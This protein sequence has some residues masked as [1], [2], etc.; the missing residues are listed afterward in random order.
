[1]EKGKFIVF[2]GVDG[3][4]TTTQLDL[5][6]NSLMQSGVPNITTQEPTGRKIGKL[7]RDFL[8]VE[9]ENLPNTGMA[10][11]FMADRADH[12]HN[13]IIP[14]LE[15]GNH[16]LC[17][18]YLLSTLAYQSMTCPIQWLR[19]LMSFALLPDLTILIDVPLDVASQRV[20]ARKGKAKEIYEISHVQQHVSDAYSTL[21]EQEKE[22][23]NIVRVDGS[24]SQTEVASLVLAEVLKAFP[25]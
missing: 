9:T 11:L 14:E 3:S 23:H 13:V 1:M 5:L 24:G 19:D 22:S 12:I 20:S 17:D 25:Q 16:V 2:E 6:S 4:G 21:Y 7:L 15:A 18:R 10:F 8:S